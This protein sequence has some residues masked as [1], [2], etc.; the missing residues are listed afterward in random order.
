MWFISNTNL[1]ITPTIFNNSCIATVLKPNTTL[2]DSGLITRLF[3]SSTTVINSSSVT[4]IPNT[5]TSITEIPAYE[6]TIPP[7]ISSP[8]VIIAPGST[9]NI[10]STVS[11]PV[12]VNINRHNETFINV[13]NPINPSTIYNEKFI[14]VNNPINRVNNLFRPAKNV[15]N[16]VS[17]EFV[18]IGRK[19]KLY[20]NTQIVN[21]TY[22]GHKTTQSLGIPLISGLTGLP[23]LGDINITDSWQDHPSAS[24]TLVT[25]I[26][27]ISNFRQRFVLGS[28]FHIDRFEFIVTSYS[29]DLHT[30]DDIASISIGLRG[31]WEIY[32]NQT[33]PIIESSATGGLDPECAVSGNGLS[34]V[35]ILNSNNST[36]YVTYLPLTS[37]VKRIGAS[38]IGI[39]FNIKVDR[40]NFNATTT[41]SNELS[42]YLDINGSFIDYSNPGN[43]KV[44]KLDSV[45]TLNIHDGDLKAGTS[46]STSINRN[47][48][49]PTSSSSG[50]LNNQIR[51][52]SLVPA[53]ITTSAYGITTENISIIAHP[54]IYNF[55]TPDTFEKNGE[56]IIDEPTKLSFD[57]YIFRKPVRKE[58]RAGDVNQGNPNSTPECPQQVKKLTNLD[59]NYDRSGVTK[60]V[61]DKVEED[62]FPITE[63][64]SRYGFA[65]TAWDITKFVSSKQSR[66]PILEEDNPN[67]QWYLIEKTYKTYIYDEKTGYLLGYDI[68]GK[69]L[70]RVKTEGEDLY[71]QKYNINIGSA[72]PSARDTAKYNNL[73]FSY[74]PV[75]AAKRY[76]LASYA[77][78]YKQ[79]ESEDK[80]IKQCN[81]DGS[82]SWI[83]NPN[84]IEPMFVMA[85]SEEYSC[86]I[87]KDNPDNLVRQSSDP[88]QPPLSTG[89][90]TFNRTTLSILH[91]KNT[92]PGFV[93]DDESEDKYLT[94]TSN[95]T[96]QDPGFGSVTETTSTSESNGIPSPQSHKPPKHILEEPSKVRLH[97]VTPYHYV[98]WTTPYTGGYPRTGTYNFEKAKD[99]LQVETA[100]LNQLRIDDIRN[101]LSSTCTVLYNTNIKSG[102][103]V[104]VNVNGINCKR[105]ITSVTHNI[106]IE[107]LDIHQIPH[108]TSNG[109]TLNMGIERD[110]L[111]L[112]N[113]KEEGIPKP[114]NIILDVTKKGFTMGNLL[115]SSSYTRRGG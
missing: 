70:I 68:N 78:Y 63:I 1:P 7:G 96:A 2:T 100:V 30:G 33:I 107:G 88:I 66:V 91:S 98:F 101:T 3:D 76:L 114:N 94:F 5:T 6:I 110:L 38:V 97:I 32:V 85:E 21:V 74:V 93:N 9:I 31:K 108:M 65:Y 14:N 59:M 53:T 54:L 61:I 48:P 47:P 103:K 69:K 75:Y 12:P 39:N 10:P 104:N 64:T 113:R 50:T 37:L 35:S 90:E 72:T 28:P 25:N 57:R 71:T 105:R 99:I 84:Y 55:T 106:K 46:F 89:Q 102:D 20:S 51:Y 45:A 40:H 17:G 60:T 11:N 22:P 34:T 83:T 44:T 58:Y 19:V 27:N 92:N 81:R 87:E 16:P 86:Y 111:G 8:I 109:T 62:G 4:P 26:N 56:R 18:V 29:E 79:F 15:N 13:N 82:S 67:N 41:I 49:K 73:L 23:V 52:N 36:G 77:D 115:D 95:F 80:F 24:M 43:I 42:N 112:I